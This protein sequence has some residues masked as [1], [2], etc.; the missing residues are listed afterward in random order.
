MGNELNF[1]DAG[2]R[3]RT[4]TLIDPVNFAQDTSSDYGPLFREDSLGNTARNDEFL[5]TLL[6]KLSLTCNCGTLLQSQDTGGRG[7]KLV[8]LS[9]IA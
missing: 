1:S 6:S 8:G 9:H 5:D 4:S 7:R 3:M 2:V